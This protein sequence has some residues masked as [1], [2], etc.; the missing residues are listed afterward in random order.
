MDLFHDKCFIFANFGNSQIKLGIEFWEEYLQKV[1]VF[2]LNLIEMKKIF[3]CLNPNMQLSQII[4]WFRIRKINVII[5]SGKLGAIGSYK[6][7]EK[8]LIFAPPIKT[9]EFV[10]STG[11]G[12]AFI[13]GLAS[14]ISQTND[15]SF[16][17]YCDAIAEARIWAAYACTTLGAASNCPTQNEIKVFKANNLIGVEN[18]IKIVPAKEA[19]N[20][21]DIFDTV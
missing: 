10:D 19:E 5:T 3:S 12:D 14:R 20:I 17:R 4:E 7:G 2:Q 6:D 11:A 9:F 15:L 13:G 8:G 18:Q 16:E 1:C 21:L